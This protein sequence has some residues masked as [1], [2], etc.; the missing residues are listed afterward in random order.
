MANLR[1]KS[2]YDHCKIGSNIKI[3]LDGMMYPVS[4][5][6]IT[7]FGMNYVQGIRLLSHKINSPVT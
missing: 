2:S 5:S 1:V 7:V 6:K 4:Q 3:A